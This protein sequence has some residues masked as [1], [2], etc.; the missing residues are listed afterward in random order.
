M[1]KSLCYFAS[2]FNI[3][4]EHRSASSAESSSTDPIAIPHQPC[5]FKFPKKKI[6]QWHRS[7]Q[8]KWFNDFPWL[9]YI[10]ESNSVICFVCAD[11]NK[12]G[13]LS[14]AKKKEKT[15]IEDV[16]S[17]WKKAIVRFQ[18]HQKSDCHDLATEHQIGIIAS[19]GNVIS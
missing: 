8:P 4:V 7:F 12:Q 14:I 9:H 19:S 10:E 16:F 3:V 15:F 17:N 18:E 6:G 13:K 11:Q 1:S 5:N 2:F